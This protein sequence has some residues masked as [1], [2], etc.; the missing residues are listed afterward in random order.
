MIGSCAHIVIGKTKDWCDPVSDRQSDGDHRNAFAAYRR[1][2]AFTDVLLFDD[3]ANRPQ[4]HHVE[5][6]SK[7][8]EL[9][10]RMARFEIEPLPLPIP[11]IPQLIAAFAD[12]Q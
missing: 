1:A 8:V 5:K 4:Y 11:D 7:P 12:P 9:R 10:G 6:L 3:Y 2:D